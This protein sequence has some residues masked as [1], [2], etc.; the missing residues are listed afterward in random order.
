MTG[1]ATAAA[2]DAG[3]VASSTAPTAGAGVGAV[4]AK[5]FLVGCGTTALAVGSE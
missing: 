1:G 2:T 4:M 5:S 3:A